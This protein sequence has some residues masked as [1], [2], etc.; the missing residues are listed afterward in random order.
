MRDTRDRESS[1]PQDAIF[2]A[3]YV[4]MVRGTAQHSRG[5]RVFWV[6][7]GCSSP[8]FYNILDFM[9]LIFCPVLSVSIGHDGSCTYTHVYLIPGR[10]AISTFDLIVHSPGLR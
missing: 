1:P 10:Q 4:G 3:G 6:L 7:L 2:C 5:M 9:F 8:H